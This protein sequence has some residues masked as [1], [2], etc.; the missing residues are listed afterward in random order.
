MDNETMRITG[1]GKSYAGN[2]ALVD[3]NMV[4]SAGTVHALI[5]ENGAGKSTLVKI[6]SG[7][8]K[9]DSGDISFEAK[10]YNPH[11]PADAQRLGVVAVH[12]ELS[13]SPYLPVYQNIWLGHDE[14]RSGAFI[15]LG[16]LR[17]R[18]EKLQAEYSTS[19]DPERWVSDLSLE[20]QQ[21]VEILKA[22][23]YEPRV[24]ILDEP[25]SA[26][27]AENTRWLLDLIERLK[28]RGSAILFISHRMPEVM[29]LADVLT[30]LKDGKKVGTVER[31]KVGP[32]DVVRM[33]VGRDLQD[34]FPEKP[35]RAEIEKNSTLLEVNGLYA[36]KV[37]HVDFEVK[38][39]EIV[40]LAGLEGQG[41]HELLLSLFGMHTVLDGE[42]RLKGRKVTLRSPTRAIAALGFGKHRSRHARPEEELGLGGPSGGT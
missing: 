18:T 23:A 41:Q 19:I 17:A 21:V 30:V 25:T 22:L 26:L 31:S 5:G 12:Q 27:G 16:D 28:K 9:S 33:M 3:M 8:L 4:L 1:V 39:G 6:V 15:N 20:E 35:D 7:G 32:D 42:V 40:G 13:L 38:A 24:I 29:E 34:I 36:E 10:A 11:S 37:L 14:K 2:P